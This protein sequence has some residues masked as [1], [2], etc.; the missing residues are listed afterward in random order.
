[1]TDN[2]PNATP[3]SKILGQSQGITGESQENLNKPLVDSTGVSDED[4]AF[5]NDV[6]AKIE[7]GQINIYVPSSLI[8]SEVY[9]KL[10]EMKQGKVDLNAM[11]LL[12]NVRQIKDLHEMGSMDTYQAQNIV[13]SCRLMKERVEQ[14]HGNCYII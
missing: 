9:D 2:K 8:N 5:L 10:D 12:S 11:T 3:L 1:M 14:E 13:N 7:S 4:Q 6:I